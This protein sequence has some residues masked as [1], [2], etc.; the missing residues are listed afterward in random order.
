MP[1]K[2]SSV[3]YFSVGESQNSVRHTSRLINIIAS[4]DINITDPESVHSS[5]Q[6]SLAAHPINNPAGISTIVLSLIVY[7]I[8]GIVFIFCLYRLALWIRAKGKQQEEKKIEHQGQTYFDTNAA[9]ELCFDI[10]GCHCRK[11]LKN[12]MR[13]NGWCPH[14]VGYLGDF[15]SDR[16]IKHLASLRPLEQPQTH[17]NCNRQ[18][19][20]GVYNIDEQEYETLHRCPN[21]SCGT[22]TVPYS[23]LLDV[24]RSGDI[25]VISIE[26]LSNL[27]LVTEPGL[28]LRVHRAQY[29]TLGR[30]RVQRYVAI[31]HVWAHGLGNPELNALPECQLRAMKDRLDALSEKVRL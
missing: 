20:C 21:N 26:A 29:R 28:E 6:T 5:S 19:D 16:I 11:C 15:Y 7:A 3:V 27:D 18:P 24:L 25:P 8:G 1:P 22:I 4:Q 31:S 13:Q 14:Q 23:V 30:S 12:A 2:P 9:R 17:T 10:P